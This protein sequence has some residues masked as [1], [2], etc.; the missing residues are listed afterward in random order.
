MVVALQ[1]SVVQPASPIALL[2]RPL[3]VRPS[4][5]PF[6]SAVLPCKVRRS[7]PSCQMGSQMGVLPH[8]STSPILQKESHVTF[9]AWQRA[10]LLFSN[11]LLTCSRECP[12]TLLSFF[13]PG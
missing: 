6:F 10:G 8:S 1:P 3:L 2:R 9:C 13:C 4:R 12:L 11:L 5:S 7:L